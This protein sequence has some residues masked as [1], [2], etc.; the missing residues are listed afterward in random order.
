[1]HWFAE[2]PFTGSQVCPD[3]Q[4]LGS[5]SLEHP[6]VPSEV[7]LHFSTVHAMPSFGQFAAVQQVPHTA[8]VP[9]ALGQHMP[10]AQSEPAEHVRS[11]PHVLG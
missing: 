11:L 4:R 8:V 3:G 1:L 5:G 2:H 9:S 10:V 7:A 6:S